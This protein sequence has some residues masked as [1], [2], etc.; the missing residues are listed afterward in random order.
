MRRVLGDGIVHG[1]Y[2]AIGTGDGIT[3][4]FVDKDLFTCEDKDQNVLFEEEEIGDKDENKDEG[5]DIEIEADI[6]VRAEDSGQQISPPETSQNHSESEMTS[7][8]NG[9]DDGNVSADWLVSRTES[10]IDREAYHPE[11]GHIRAANMQELNRLLLFRTL[12]TY[13]LFFSDMLVIVH[14]GVC[15][16][17]LECS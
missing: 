8:R 13:S 16:Q 15:F 12:I 6:D 10:L 9:P 14:G 17:G 2:L 7:P 5:E 11:A 3:E 1:E 4:D